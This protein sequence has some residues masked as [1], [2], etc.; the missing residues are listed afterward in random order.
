MIFRLD[1]NINHFNNTQTNHSTLQR[2]DDREYYND[3]PGKIPP[4]IVNLNGKDN[5]NVFNGSTVGAKVIPLVT[6]RN[7]NNKSSNTDSLNDI[8]P[9]SANTLINLIDL[10]DDNINSTDNVSMVHSGTSNLNSNICLTPNNSN[11]CQLSKILNS[12]N[13][14][15]PHYV[16]CTSESASEVKDPFDMRMFFYFNW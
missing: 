10:N 9:S 5:L 13:P 6:P 8:E 16:N 7:K 12:N 4:D 15:D 11:N 14:N 3:L 2:I 1:S